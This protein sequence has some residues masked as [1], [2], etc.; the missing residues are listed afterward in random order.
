MWFVCLANAS[1]FR[2]ADTQLKSSSIASSNYRIHRPVRAQSPHHI[3]SKP[4]NVC[5]TE[6]SLY[7]Y[8]RHAVLETYIAVSSRLSNRQP[9]VHDGSQRDS[10]SIL[11]G[12][13]NSWR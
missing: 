6:T 11:A 4:V 2:R 1:L 7:V 13:S 12:A 10:P 9:S 3:L 5:S 8:V